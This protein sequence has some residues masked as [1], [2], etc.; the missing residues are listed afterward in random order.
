MQQRTPAGRPSGTDGSD[1]SYR[2]V[3]DSRYTK[4][5]KGKSHL[6]ALILVQAVFYLVGLSLAFLTTKAEEERNILAVSAAGIGL[7]SSLIGELGRRRSRAIF[8]RVYMAASSVAV[9]LS[10]FCAVK[11]R[12]T[13]EERENSETTGKFELIEF[14]CAQLGALVQIFA[15]ITTSSLVS[16]MSPPKKTL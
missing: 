10:V 15:I 3:V 13:M 7:V 11:N 14:A 1:F 2:M 9:V 5:A 8:L 4:V 12:L 16:N 6:R